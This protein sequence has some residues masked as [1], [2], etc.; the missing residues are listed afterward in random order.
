MGAVCG[1]TSSNSPVKP[2]QSATTSSSGY[3]KEKSGIPN[4]RD[5]VLVAKEMLTMLKAK[6]TASAHDVA[7]EHD[8]EE[9]PSAKTVEASTMYSKN[10]EIRSAGH[11]A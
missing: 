4:H 3:K 10:A 6:R 5:S 2:M 7:G 8:A 9:T 1:K 11:L